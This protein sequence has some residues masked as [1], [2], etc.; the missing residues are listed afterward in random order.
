MIN[1]KLCILKNSAVIFIC[2]YGVFKEIKKYHF[3]LSKL[4]TPIHSFKYSKVLKSV[5]IS[6]YI[7]ERSSF[8]I[9]AQTFL[10]TFYREN[11]PGMA[12]IT[13]NL[14]LKMQ[15]QCNKLRTQHCRNMSKLIKMSLKYHFLP[16]LNLLVLLIMENLRFKEAI[17]I[18]I[19]NTLIIFSK[20]S[21]QAKILKKIPKIQ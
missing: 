4:L 19:Y 1:F 3:K 17:L 14:F 8:K 7:L 2:Y 5:I 20:D 15:K 12:S 21:L 10:K 18:L 13:Q 11:L 16:V 9:C 6:L